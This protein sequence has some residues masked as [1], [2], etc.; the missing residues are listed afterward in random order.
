MLTEMERAALRRLLHESGV[1]RWKAQMNLAD[2][3]EDE[4]IIAWEQDLLASRLDDYT[5]DEMRRHIAQEQA[6]FW[7]DACFAMEDY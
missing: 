6:S 4:R 7:Q 5:P 2:A 3:L 1:T